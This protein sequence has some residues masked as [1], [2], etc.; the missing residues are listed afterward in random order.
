[1]I[2]PTKTT[3]A[4]IIYFIFAGAY[5]YAFKGVDP[6]ISYVTYGVLN[7][8][9]IAL[10]LFCYGRRI[11]ENRWKTSREKLIKKAQDG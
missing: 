4:A 1:L 2:I 7:V 10:L 3:A 5:L 11:N 9:P 6:T 8:S